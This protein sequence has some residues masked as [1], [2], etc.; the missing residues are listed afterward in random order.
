MAMRF[1]TL[2]GCKR[3]V[4]RTQQERAHQ[5]NAFEHLAQDTFLQRFDVDD[6]IRE[7]GHGGIRQFYMQ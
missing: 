6:N 2:R 3:R 5:S 1:P 7:F 4:H